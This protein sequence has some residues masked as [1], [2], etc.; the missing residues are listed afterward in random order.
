MNEAILTNSNGDAYRLLA[1]DLDGTLIA[2]HGLMSACAICALKNVR[3]SGMLVVISTGRAWAMIPLRLRL[4]R[5][6]AF[7]TSNGARVVM[8]GG[9]SL[10]VRPIPER[11]ALD[12]ISWLKEQGAAVNAFYNGKALFDRDAARMVIRAGGRISLRRIVFFADFIRHARTASGIRRC[13]QKKRTAVEKI[14]GMFA[15]ENEAEHALADLS[16]NG[17]LTAVTTGGN[18]IEITADGVDKGDALRRLC[19]FFEV[20]RE[21]VIVC[22]DSGNYLSMRESCGLFGAPG[23]ASESVRKAAD[24][25]TDCVQKDGVAKWLLK[26]LT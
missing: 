26:N 24:V 12:T 11:L 16:G 6:D 10:F 15:T 20:K 22:G 3:S 9:K 23:N 17:S 18:D 8:R 1:C 14:G 19:E 25:I 13:L 21:Q 2:N 7:I 4:F 5:A